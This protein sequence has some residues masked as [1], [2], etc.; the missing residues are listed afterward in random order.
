MEKIF[1]KLV[2]TLKE[3]FETFYLDHNFGFKGCNRPL[4]QGAFFYGNF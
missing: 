4:L 1:I 2:K 3:A